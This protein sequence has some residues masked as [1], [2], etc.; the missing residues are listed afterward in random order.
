MDHIRLKLNTD[1]TECI[2]FRSR[3]HLN[4]IDTTILFNAD[5]DLIQINNVVRYF[6]GYID[7]NFNFKECISVKV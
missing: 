2:Q 5:G 7:C 6:G 3:Q 1:K 4:K